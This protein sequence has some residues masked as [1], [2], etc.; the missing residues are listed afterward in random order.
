MS[1][2]FD[3]RW[4]CKRDTAANWTSNNP[5]LLAG[6]WGMETDTKKTKIGDGTT[7]W[8]ALA[9][10]S[11]PQNN[12]AITGG[13]ITGITDLAVADG[14]TGLSVFAVGDI[15]HATAATT[16]AG[17]ADVAAGA[18]LRSG[19]ITTVPLWSTL[20]LPNA[21]TAYR[22]PV[23]TSANTIGE[24]AA[25]GATGEYLAGNTGAIPSWTTLNQAAVAGLTTA[26]GPTFDHLHVT[27]NADI[28]VWTGK[29]DPI[30]AHSTIT[31]SAYIGNVGANTGRFRIGSNA[32]AGFLQWNSYYDGA[33]VKQMDTTKP[34]FG[35]N[36]GGFNDTI[37]FQ[38]ATAGSNPPTLLN[39]VTVLGTGKV[40][41]GVI[42]PQ[43][44]EE[45]YDSS[46]TIIEQLR[47]TNADA[48]GAGSKLSFYQY[49]AGYAHEAS[50]KAYY[51]SGWCWGL[52]VGTGADLITVLGSGRVGIGVTVPNELLE[53]N[54]KIRALTAF[55]L[56]GADGISSTLT[57]DDGA[58]WRITA[59][60]AG[61]ILTAKTTAA[62]SGQCATWS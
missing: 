42:T 13:S 23:A 61:G 52:D 2:I 1:G 9:Y 43:V 5:V 25:V 46:A 62:S 24:L 21:A 26:D 59:T 22:L 30:E 50:M 11:S 40:G 49:N 31:G 20:I 8:N 48:G 14:G 27:N 33:A 36:F 32:N 10:G 19:G 41:L 6:E 56:N 55:N 4:Q 37:S 45:I 29:P 3:A 38:R 7:V 28:G 12:V 58:N 57:L 34:S 35:I 53:V 51:S 54:G 18:Y 17:L 60:F 15:V 16:L 44:H 39:L 47:L